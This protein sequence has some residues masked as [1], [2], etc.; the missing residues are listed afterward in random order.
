MTAAIILAAGESSRLGQPKQNLSFNGQTL[1]ERVV[2]AAQQSNCDPVLIVL[3]ANSDQIDVIKNATILYNENW[4]EGMA[5]SIR[6]GINSINDNPSIDKVIILV[7]DQP[8]LTAELLNSII[9]KQ[10]ETNKPIVACTYNGT[11]GVPAL[12]GR[13]FFAELLQLQGQEGAKKIIQAH[14]DV[15]TTIPFELGSID[16][17]TPEDLEK[18]THQ[19]SE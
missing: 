19:K 7:C 13:T 6:T 11:I 15:I 17:D 3:G 9:K 16:I 5:S 14:A 10:A 18:L 8:F 4:P 1:L 2:D 12:F